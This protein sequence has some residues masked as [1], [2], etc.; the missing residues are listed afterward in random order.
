MASGFKS[1]S[2]LFSVKIG[3]SSTVNVN[4]FS[5]NS[6]WTLCQPVMKIKVRKGGRGQGSYTVNVSSCEVMETSY[7][8]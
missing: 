3:R 2:F 4:I 6:N 7:M 1:N 8:V 5:F